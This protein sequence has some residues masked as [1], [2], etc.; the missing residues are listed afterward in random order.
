MGTSK[1]AAPGIAA[2]L[3]ALGRDVHW[4]SEQTAITVETIERAA[5][6]IEALSLFD[7]VL[8]AV[9]LQTSPP[10]LVDGG[11]TVTAQELAEQELRCSVQQVYRM[12]REGD[13]PGTRVGRSW[14]FKV[15]EV[16]EAL[17]QAPVDLWA[18]RSRK[19]VRT[20]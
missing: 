5:K 6:D 14:R 4:L 18:P 7:A 19:K 3:T 11:D 12:A 1:Q 15:A 8:I 9:A 17:K 16:R 20:V 10:A 2:R 13:I